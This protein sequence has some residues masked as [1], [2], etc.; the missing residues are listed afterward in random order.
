[1]QTLHIQS[2][3]SLNTYN[4]HSCGSNFS[5]VSG[6]LAYQYSTDTQNF[7]ITQIA[8]I[9]WK[10]IKKKIREDDKYDKKSKPLWLYTHTHTHTHL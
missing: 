1:M 9:V 3:Y 6:T 7:K 5:I 10:K 2:G 8:A 4:N